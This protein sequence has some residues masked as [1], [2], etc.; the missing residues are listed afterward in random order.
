MCAEYT[1]LGAD[2]KALTQETGTTQITL[3]MAENAWNS[4]PDA[5]SY[6]IYSLDFEADNLYGDNVKVATAWEGSVDLYSRFKDGAG[7]VPLICGT[8][9]VHCDGAWSLNSH[10]YE[11]ETGFF[12]WEWT[13]QVEG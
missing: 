5:D 10:Q 7:W 12:H 8:L 4:R 6:G 1:A 3:P 9:T 2:L 13:F 11:H